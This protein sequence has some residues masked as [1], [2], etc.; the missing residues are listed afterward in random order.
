MDWPGA[1][2]IHRLLRDVSGTPHRRRRSW[3]GPFTPPPRF[4]ASVESGFCI[5]GRFFFGFLLVYGFCYFFVCFQFFRFL[6]VF[7]FFPVSF[8][9]FL[10]NLNIFKF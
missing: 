4:P 8:L 2:P 10:K 3:A 5:F 9:N 7:L 1:K 6:L